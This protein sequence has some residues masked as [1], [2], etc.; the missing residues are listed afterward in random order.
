MSRRTSKQDDE[1]HI[2]YRHMMLQDG[3]RHIPVY[4]FFVCNACGK[5]VGK[6]Y[7]G[8]PYVYFKPGSL[9]D[10]CDSD[11]HYEPTGIVQVIC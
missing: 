7:G 6:E 11:W 9:T 5:R 1:L 8:Y 4:L 10:C 3:H 2:K